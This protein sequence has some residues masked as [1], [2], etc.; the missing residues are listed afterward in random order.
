[1]AQAAKRVHQIAHR[2]IVALAAV[3]TLLFAT[4]ASAQLWPDPNVD[5]AHLGTWAQLDGR[6]EDGKA[7]DE[8][9]LLWASDGIPKWFAALDVYNSA[10]GDFV[11]GSIIPPSAAMPNGGMHDT[12]Y[13]RTYPGEGNAIGLNMTPPM[14]GRV[15]IGN[16]STY[17][18]PSSWPSLWIANGQGQTGE[19]IRV[20]DGSA[21]RVTGRWLPNGMIEATAVATPTVNAT[22]VISTSVT[23]TGLA[24]AAVQTRELVMKNAAGAHVFS[25]DGRGRLRFP[26]G[27]TLFEGKAGGLVWRSANGRTTRLARP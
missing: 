19:A 15:V 13:L 2:T 24:S 7:V 3:T 14:R 5:P 27:G 6:T 23:T 26:K 20:T 8:P 11:I 17:A 18:K 9:V 22:R 4:P 1:M 16:D 25:V 10:N 21:E 12:V